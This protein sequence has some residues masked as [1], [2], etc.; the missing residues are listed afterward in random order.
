MF[1][2]TE[3]INTDGTKMKYSLLI[4]YSAM[5]CDAASIFFICHRKKNSLLLE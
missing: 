1:A 4:H 2:L 3:I 5:K